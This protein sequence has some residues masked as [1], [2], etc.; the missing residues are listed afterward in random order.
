M[1]EYKNSVNRIMVA[2]LSVVGFA[3]TY[4]ICWIANAEFKHMFAI[5]MPFCICSRNF[6]DFIWYNADLEENEEKKGYSQTKKK[7]FRL[8][9]NV[10]YG[11]AGKGKR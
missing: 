4:G 11:F 9:N 2:L 3:I 5:T 6:L 1:K 10:I 8:W 7:E